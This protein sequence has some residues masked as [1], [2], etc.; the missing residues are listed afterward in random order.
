MRYT[1]KQILKILN[2]SKPTLYKLCK[3]RKIVAKKTVGGHCRYSDEDV[4]ELLGDQINSKDIETKFIETV[5]DVW[6]I[7]K[8]LS[9]E[10]WGMEKGQ[11]KLIEILQK[12]KQDIFILN[13]SNFQGE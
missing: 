13:L 10:I 3:D 4:K 8:K 9:E 2:V 1:T 11:E 6:L 7:L 5:N 12:N